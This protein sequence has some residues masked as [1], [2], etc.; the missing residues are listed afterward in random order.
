MFLMK[1][2]LVLQ[3]HCYWAY[4]QATSVFLSEPWGCPIP[5]TSGLNLRKRGPRRETSLL[6]KAHLKGILLSEESIFSQMLDNGSTTL[7]GKIYTLLP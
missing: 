7:W 5:G 1:G 3:A 4:S 2:T 6:P